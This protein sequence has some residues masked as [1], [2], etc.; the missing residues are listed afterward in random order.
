[1]ILASISLKPYI[2]PLLKVYRSGL[3][4]EV[5]CLERWLIKRGGERWPKGNLFRECGLF[6]DGEVA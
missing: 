4:R 1:M 2:L 3:I 5:V 6:R